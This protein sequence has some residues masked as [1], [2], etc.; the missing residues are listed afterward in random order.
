VAL[1]KTVQEFNMW[2]SMPRKPGKPSEYLHKV[3]C[4]LLSDQRIAPSIREKYPEVQ[5]DRL[6]EAWT[7]KLQQKDYVINASLYGNIREFSQKVAYF[8]HASLQGT[9]C[10]ATAAQALRSVKGAGLA[11]GLL[12]DAQ[13]FTTVQLGRALSQQDPAAKLD[14]LVDTDLRA[15]SYDLK[16]RK[17]SERLFKQVLTELGHRGITPEK[18]LHIGSRVSLDVA[19][20]RRLGM[21]TGLFAGDVASLEPNTTEQLKDPANRPDVLLTKLSQIADVIG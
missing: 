10:Y 4:E 12:T 2:A 13:C 17:P 15:C 7:R 19:P 18:I 9:A 11:Q 20:A 21:K 8:F 6:W 16:A 1:D 14:E 3:Y 5:A